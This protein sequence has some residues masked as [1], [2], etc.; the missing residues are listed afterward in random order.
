MDTRAEQPV[1]QCE[2]ALHGIAHRLEGEFGEMFTRDTIDH[3]VHD[4]YDRMA[5]TWRIATHIPAFVERFSRQRLRALAKNRGIVAGH[6]P[7][8][9]FVCARNDA[10]SQMAVGLF[11]LCAQGRATA[12]SAGAVPASELRAEAV[13][14]MDEVGGDLSAQ[15]TRPVTPE[16][17]AA[18][19]VVVTLDAH[20]D[21]PIVDDKRYVAWRM[22]P[23]EGCPPSRAF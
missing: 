15:F 1:V 10:A 19:D 4:S 6:R 14:V 7:E 8:V 21:I 3:H 17:E 9:L 22:P 23:A 11:N 13:A 16:V 18:A 20:D 2:V 12:H 5:A